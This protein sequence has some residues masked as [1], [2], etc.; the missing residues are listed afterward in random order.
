MDWNDPDELRRLGELLG[1]DPSRGHDDRGRRRSRH[2]HRRDAR[3]AARD[4]RHRRQLLHVQ[5]REQ[6]PDL[7]LPRRVPPAR[8]DLQG[9]RHD[10]V[11]RAVRD[12]HLA[13]R[14]ERGLPGPRRPG[15]D[16]PVPA[17]STGPA[18]SLLV[19][20][21]TPWTLTSNVAAAVG[22]TIRYVRVR[23]GDDDLLARAR[24][25]SRPRSTGPFEVLDEVSGSEMVGWRY[26]GPFD[27]LPAVRHAFAGGTRDDPGPAVRAPGRA[28]DRGR[29]GRGDRDRPHRPG[30]RRRGLP[31]GQGARAAGRRAARRG[32]HLPRRVR[33]AVGSRRPR[34]RRPD[35]RAPQARGPVLPARDDHPPLPAL[36]ALRDAARLPPRRR[37]V[38]QHGSAL[39]PAARD[40]DRRAGRRQ[41][42]LPDH[43]RGR[44]DPLDP[45]L[46]LRA[47]ARLAPQ[48][49]RLDDQQEAL[50]G[51]GAADLRL[52]GVRHGR[53]HRRARGAPATGPSTGWE[54]FEG[55]TP[56]RPYVDAVRIACP[57]CGAPVERIK[58][59]GNPVARRRDR[60]VLDAPLPRGPRLLAP[61][62]PGRLH[63]R[64]LPGPVPQLV[65]LDARDVARSCAASRRSRRSSATRWCS[66]RTAARCTRAG[67][68]RS[69]S[70]RPPTGW[71]STSCAGCSPRRG[72][73]RTSC[74]AGTPPTRRAASCSI[75]WNVYSFFVTYARLAGWTPSEARAAASPTGRSS[76]AGSCRGRPGRP[77]AVEARLA[78]LRRGRCD[79][80]AV[81]ATSTGCRPGTCACRAAASRGPTTAADQAAAFATLH[82][83]LVAT[84]RM[85][86]PILPFL[87]ESLYGNLVTTVDADAPDSVH[88][89][90]LAER[91]PGRPSRRARWRRSMAIAQGAVDL[92]RTLRSTAHLKTRQPLATAWLA[93]PGPRARRSAT[94]L[95][96]AHRRRDQRQGGRRHRRRL[97]ARRAAGQAAAAEDRQAARV[98]DPRGHGRGPRRARSTFEADGSVTLG[99]V[100]L[101]PDEV[102]IQ[103]TPRPGTAVAH[104]DGLVVVLDTDADARAASP[105]ATPASW[106]ARSRTCGARPRLELDDRIDLWVRRPARRPSPPHLPA[107]AAD[108][109]AV[110]AD[111]DPPAD[112]TP[113]RRSSSTA[114]GS[115]S[116]CAAAAADR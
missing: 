102:E 79:A 45:G 13:D 8:L 28:V 3:R 27:D 38:H 2:R 75:L 90:P 69:S 16:R 56:H 116:R 115:R 97:G 81:G 67:A 101:A 65:L 96:A 44:P 49:A 32:R 70:T 86:A 57:S 47:R 109:L 54:D 42:A 99:G 66:P 26:A 5:Q 59:V 105:R 14:D 15:P 35:R 51:P 60:A 4:A 31:A 36:L 9:P 114:A 53:G 18:R 111:G 87:A 22:P 82:E 89:T 113:A 73:R 92:A 48:H 106:P 108:T 39:R 100:T 80:R 62:V 23:Q 94:D 7:G 72:R 25:R 74:S 12:G 83:A 46:R 21:T 95:L 30:L 77:T 85:L 58:D 112:A 33:A 98:G 19:W 43:G 84:A 55:H 1:T 103:A 24:G 34:R 50:L 63:H 91:R 6:R 41:P 68:T 93:L 29:G 11:V 78:R 104:H 64:E 40:A 110:L 37:V 71:A 107:V 52:H 88:L 10:A 17:A 76:T 20:T 61:V